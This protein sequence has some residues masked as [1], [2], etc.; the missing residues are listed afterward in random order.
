MVPWNEYKIAIIMSIFIVNC[1]IISVIYHYD[2]IEPKS[3][4]IFAMCPQDSIPKTTLV[5][6]SSSTACSWWGN[7]RLLKSIQ[8]CEWSEVSSMIKNHKDRN[9]KLIFSSALY[10]LHFGLLKC[11]ISHTWTSLGARHYCLVVLLTWTKPQ[12]YSF[13][14]HDK[15]DPQ[16]IGRNSS[17]LATLCGTEFIN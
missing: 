4:G 10:T 13:V 17:V 16:T 7:K 11:R 2:M 5:F 1:E 8:W 12:F 3:Y 14:S 15:T 9:I 6:I